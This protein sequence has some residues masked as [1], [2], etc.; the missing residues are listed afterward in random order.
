MLCYGVCVIFS[1]AVADQDFALN[2]SSLSFESGQTTNAIVVAILDDEIFESNESFTLELSVP[3][4]FRMKD[5]FEGDPNKTV[6]VIKD[7]DSE[8]SSLIATCM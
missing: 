8:F 7:D 2:L 1:F 5:V 3:E 6:I 4:T